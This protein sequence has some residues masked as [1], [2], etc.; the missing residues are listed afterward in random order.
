MLEATCVTQ[1]LVVVPLSGVRGI[2]LC[3]L[4]L[5]VARSVE[6]CCTRAIR[7]RSWARRVQLPSSIS[8]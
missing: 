1:L 5:G 2:F 7:V 6:Q 4:V 8:I 3:L